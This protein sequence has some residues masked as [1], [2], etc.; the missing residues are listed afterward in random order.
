MSKLNGY[1]L[2]LEEKGLIFFNERSNQYERD[3]AWRGDGCENTH[4]EAARDSLFRYVPER[5]MGTRSRRPRGFLSQGRRGQERTQT[6][7]RAK[8]RRSSQVL[9]WKKPIHR[10]LRSRLLLRGAKQG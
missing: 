5:S 6:L 9:Y 3:Q 7:G 8:R 1:L 10:G 2:E 4:D